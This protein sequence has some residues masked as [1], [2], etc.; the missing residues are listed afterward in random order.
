MSIKRPRYEYYL[1]EL[2]DERRKGYN[3]HW[4]IDH[5][6]GG[7]INGQFRTST[8]VNFNLNLTGYLPFCAVFDSKESE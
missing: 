6:P 3:V 5:T 2:Q 1:N 7:E 4:M 8:S